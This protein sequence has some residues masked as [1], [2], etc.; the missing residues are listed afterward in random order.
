M[1][2]SGLEP[3]RL[4]PLPP[5]DSVSTK[6]HHQ[7]AK[8]QGLIEEAQLMLAPGDGQPDNGSTVNAF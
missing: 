3:E 7:G 8:Q 4:S 6:F 1:P 5:Q 2:W